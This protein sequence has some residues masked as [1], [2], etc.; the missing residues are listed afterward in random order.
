MKLMQSFNGILVIL[1]AAGVTGV[2]ASVFEA[3]SISNP[4]AITLAQAVSDWEQVNSNGFG[5][6]QIGE[7]TALEAFNGYLYAGTFNPINPIPGQ[8]YDG[9]QIFR[10]SDGA[11][12][13]AVTQPG[14][15]NTHDI[16]P[17]AILDFVVFNNQIYAGTGRG[18]ASQIWRS[19]NGITWAPMDVTGFSDPD[20]VDITAL[21]VYNGMIYAGVRN[22]VTGAQIWR[23]FTG[24]N[25]T[26]TQIAPDTPGKVP[27]SVTGFTEFG[28]DGGLYAAIESEAPAQIWRSYGGAWEVVI[29]DGF[30]DANTLLA[31]GMAEFLGN[32]YAGAGN[33]A[34]GA[35]LWRSSDGDI[36]TQAITPGFGDSNNQQIESVY[37]FQNQLY[38]SVKNTVTGMEIWRSAD[39]TLWEQTNLDG[40]G[41]SN[42]IGTNRG[43]AT[44][45]FVGQLYVGT[46]NVVDGG[47]LWR[48]IKPNAAPTD[49]LLSNNTVDE[50]QPINTVVGALSATDPD[51]G[52]TFTFSLACAVPGADDGS[53]N[54]LG[55]NLRT[56]AVFD[57]ETKSSYNICVRVT[58]QGGLS[59]DKNFVVTVNN[60]NEAPTDIFLS[61]VTVDE[62]QPVNTVV[63]ILSATDPDTGATF[64]FTLACAVPGADD[65]SFNILGTDLRTSAVFDFEMKS[66]YNLCV[67]VA[68]QGGL[69]FDKNFVVSVNNLVENNPPTDIL[70]SNNTVDENQPINTVVGTLS[71]VDPDAGDTFTFSLACA[72]PGADDGSFNILG[73]NLRTSALFDFETKPAYDICVRVTDQ[74]GLSFD[75]NFVVTVNNVNEA[76]TDIALSNSTVDENQ[77]INTV[78]GVL[79]AVD[80]DAGDTFTFSLACAAPGADD[81]SFNILGTNLRTSAVF[82]FETKSSY[83]IC[84]RVTDQGGLS[85]DKNFIVT[86]NNVNE[87]PT[88]ISLSNNAVDE[89]QPVNTVVGTLS[90]I[91]PDAIATFTFSLTCAFPGTDDGSFNILGTDLRTSA[92]FDFETKSAYTICVRVTDQGGLS[93][94]KNF[95]INVYNLVENAAPT[96]IA[97]SNNLVDENQPVNTVVGTL[98][99]VDPDAGDTLTFSLA[100]AVPG[101]DD[102]SFNI[103]GTDL[104]TSAVFDFE[105]KSSYNVCVRVTDQGGL[106][107]EKNFVISVNNLV[108]NNPPTDILLSNNTVDENQPVNTV[109]GALSA[110]DPDAGDTFTFS[111]ACAVPGADDGSFNILGTDLRTSAVFDFETKSSYNVCVRVADQGGLSFEKNFV[112][113]VNDIEEFT[114]TPGRVTGGGNID[115]PKSKATF[116]FVVQYDA[117]DEN[118]SGNLTFKDH[119]IKLNLKASSFTLLYI[120]DNHI[121]I[122]GLA[123]VN[124]MSDLSFTLD[125]YLQEGT[126]EKDIFMIQIPDF[127]DYSING[128]VSGGSIKIK[129]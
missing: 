124:G 44:T 37:V 101:A 73:T 49:I 122:T 11:T 36:W 108:E 9:A 94:D 128:T 16:A 92:V 17:P 93:F 81:G 53:F 40:F 5:D 90:A 12:W 99:A 97:L 20:N 72:V 46:S 8:L 98:S 18:N 33:T 27:A 3:N 79:S 64:T 67:R 80:P 45:E 24:D 52:D 31:G 110:T 56:S 10:S 48:T 76:P 23:S 4:Q 123:T 127:D 111:L 91:D 95:T 54:I 30:G 13:S 121:R 41:D 74:G 85:F 69:S 105:T 2:S 42:N 65:G 104:R 77:P 43:N 116:S 75:K 47:E 55:T 60:V 84:V 100:C 118:P 25:N 14:F 125:I 57:F 112:I 117:G 86:V 7:V 32:L 26:W 58:D 88:D 103:L 120:N 50:N 106:S 19:S 1:L 15:G 107:F 83:N 28:F 129:P 62:N 71:A 109:V 66:A 96:N 119:S 21:A 61:N 59:F 38:V 78:V 22:Q 126:G 34:V 68:D 87:A 39:G 51:A 6:P 89:N 82:D 114:N 29:N 70:L 115:L 63:G 102:G 113:S 35:Q